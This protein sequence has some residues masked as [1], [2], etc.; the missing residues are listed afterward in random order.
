MLLAMGLLE[1]KAESTWF[2]EERYELGTA[3]EL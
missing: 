3:Y 1:A 2:D